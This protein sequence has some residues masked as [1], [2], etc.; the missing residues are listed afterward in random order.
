MTKKKIVKLFIATALTF[1]SCATA[2]ASKKM[3]CTVW[4]DVGRHEKGMCVER[5]EKIYCEYGKDGAR[6]ERSSKS[7]PQCQPEWCKP[8][9]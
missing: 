3:L 2:Q 1:G 4:A 9:L 6:T 8:A 5:K 7:C